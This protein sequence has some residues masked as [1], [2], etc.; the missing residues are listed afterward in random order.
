MIRSYECVDKPEKPI[1]NQKILT[2]PSLMAK[3]VKA[4][5]YFSLPIVP[6]IP[7]C[8]GVE[9]QNG[10]TAYPIYDDIKDIS[11]DMDYSKAEYR[12]MLEALDILGADRTIIEMRGPISILDN[13]IGATKAMKA[14]RKEREVVNSLYQE[15]ISIYIDYIRRLLSKGVKVFSFAES[16]LDP[17]I[18]GPKEVSKYVD[19]F[20]F[21]FLKEVEKLT[22]KY[23]F[24]FHLCPKSSLALI[25][26]GKAKF[27]S[28]EYD[29]PKKYIDILFESSNTLMGDRCINLANR[30]FQKVNKI[31]LMEE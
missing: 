3:Y 17:K 21:D 29:Y 1:T 28:I 13:L 2:D 19:D 31:V 25:D 9:F 14:M 6:M 24:T 7:V 22:K 8:L 23:E 10:R 5:E 11:L 26:F 18:L 20:L 15:F 4:N 16:I 27:E 30:K 12:A